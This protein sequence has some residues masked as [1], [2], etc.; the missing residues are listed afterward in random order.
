MKERRIKNAVKW[1]ELCFPRK[2]NGLYTCFGHQA[3]S[4]VALLGFFEQTMH[5]MPRNELYAGE[6]C[7]AKITDM[8]FR[9]YL[10]EFSALDSRG[11]S[12]YSL[13]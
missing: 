7:R 10:G 2:N 9:L 3:S 4:S 13:W 11:F 8:M 5:G 6:T 12:S 1:K